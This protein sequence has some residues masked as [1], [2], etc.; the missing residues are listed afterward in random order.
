MKQESCE[1]LYDNNKI[2]PLEVNDAKMKAAVAECSSRVEGVLSNIHNG[3]YQQIKDQ[4]DKLR[5]EGFPDEVVN[6]MLFD[7]SQVWKNSI[8]SIRIIINTQF[9]YNQNQSDSH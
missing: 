6:Q 3:D 1:M 4:V 9:Y 2:N 5:F 8:L 7:L